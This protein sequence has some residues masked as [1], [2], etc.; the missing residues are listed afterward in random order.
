MTA[1]IVLD[2]HIHT[3]IDKDKCSVLLTTYLRS[4]FGTVDHYILLRKI[5][6]YGVVGNELELFKSYPLSTHSIEKRRMKLAN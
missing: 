4:A 6:Y 5:E 2:N 3:C 1:K